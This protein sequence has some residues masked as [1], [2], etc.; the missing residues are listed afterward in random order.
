M[1]HK[2]RES[3]EMESIG[4]RK[5]QK[6]NQ[7]RHLLS[8]ATHLQNGAP[9]NFFRRGHGTHLIKAEEA[10]SLYDPNTATLFLD[11]PTKAS[12]E[13]DRMPPKMGIVHKI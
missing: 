8:S 3:K 10:Q 1:A 2:N 13:H 9:S 12:E 4:N 5:A 6:T 7:E 11:S